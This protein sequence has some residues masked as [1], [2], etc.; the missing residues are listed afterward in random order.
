M[1]TKNIYNKDTYLRTAGLL[2]FFPAAFGALALLPFLRVMDQGGALYQLSFV[3]FAVILLGSVV[4]WIAGTLIRRDEARIIA[5]WDIFER[6]GEVDLADLV[7]STTYSRAE[8]E[9]AIPL[10]NAQPGAYFVLDRQAGRVVH[11]RLRTRSRVSEDC[12]GC[13]AR[14]SQEVV[15]DLSEGAVCPYCGA[16]L[17]LQEQVA[18]KARLLADLG[19]AGADRRLQQS[20]RLNLPLF[21]CLALFCT[22][23]AIAYFVIKMYKPGAGLTT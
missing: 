11:G 9:R 5:L 13:G 4:L 22:P 14:L 21:I 3:L 2:L 20:P 1:S 19:R 12:P 8:I 16:G 10:I 7:A 6:N 17:S 23:L 18:E 15:A